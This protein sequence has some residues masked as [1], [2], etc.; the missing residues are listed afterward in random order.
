MSKQ[1]VRVG[2]NSHKLN[3]HLLS[4]NCRTSQF[5]YRI[6]TRGVKRDPTPI[7][8]DKS[9]QFVEDLKGAWLNGVQM[10]ELIVA[11]NHVTEHYDK[12]LASVMF[13][14]ICLIFNFFLIPLRWR[15]TFKHQFN[16]R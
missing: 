4:E 9:T 3:K 12:V 14:P 5:V 10:E 13:S 8:C 11:F 16:K 2:G 15:I 6:Y 7:E 1:L